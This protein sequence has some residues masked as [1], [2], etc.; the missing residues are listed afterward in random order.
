MVL[1]NRRCIGHCG[2]RHGN[3]WSSSLLSDGLGHGDHVHLGDESTLEGALDGP[4][5]S[6]CGE[7]AVNETGETHLA[8]LVCFFL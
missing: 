3:D 2:A 1:Q 7:K 8:G 5:E 6:A 4:G